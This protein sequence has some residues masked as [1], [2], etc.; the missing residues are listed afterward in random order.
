[1]S[2]CEAYAH[3]LDE[4]RDFRNLIRKALSASLWGI[5]TEGKDIGLMTLVWKMF[6]H[7]G[8]SS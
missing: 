3:V 8:M 2:G 4:I 7:V 1:M 6:L 5:M